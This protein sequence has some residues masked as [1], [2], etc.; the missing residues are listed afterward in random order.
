MCTKAK[1][2]FNVFSEALDHYMSI[3]AVLIVNC[4]IEKGE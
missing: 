2:N 3:A 4:N 1:K